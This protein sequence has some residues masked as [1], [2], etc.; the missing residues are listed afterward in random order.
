MRDRHDQSL[1]PKHL[2]GPP[3]RITGNTEQIDKIFF[4]R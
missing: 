3:R 1:V 4:R 2:D